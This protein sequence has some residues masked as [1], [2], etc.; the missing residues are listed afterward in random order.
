M[1]DLAGPTDR[2]T[3]AHTDPI[4]TVTKEPIMDVQMNLPSDEHAA[5]QRAKVEEL[6]RRRAARNPANATASLNSAAGPTRGAP[7]RHS[8][9][10][11]SK[12]AAT[13]FGLATM[14]GLVA[15]M[16]YASAASAST[17]P[18]NTVAPAQVVVVIHPADGSASTAAVTGA[19]AVVAGAPAVV[20][21]TPSQPIA[22]TAQP[23]VRPAPVSQA[24]AAKTNGSK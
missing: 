8:P 9:A 15:A 24:P 18:A 19:P 16:G 1:T 11:G 14:F 4:K 3:H 2:N 22:L 17:P 23:T 12:I 6:Q 13:G 5:A 20:T 7:V 21:A 10:L